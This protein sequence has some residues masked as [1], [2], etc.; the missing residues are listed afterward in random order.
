M[1]N[2]ILK[3]AAGA[4][5][6]IVAGGSVAYG[7]ASFMITFDFIAGGKKLPAGAYLVVPKGS[8]QIGLKR[9]TDGAEVLV[10]YTQR[11]DPP[12]EQPLPGPR[13]PAQ[14]HLVF[15]VVGNFEP[16]YTEYVTDYVLAELWMPGEQGYLIRAMKGAHQHKT[17]TGQKTAK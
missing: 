17:V 11:L 10:A 5:V 16:S 12:A 2:A 3:L 8:D 4:L 15:D 7:Q 13:S 14:P 9:M 6:L 1:K